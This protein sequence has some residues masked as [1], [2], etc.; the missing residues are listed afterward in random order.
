MGLSSCE[1]RSSQARLFISRNERRMANHRCFAGHG[2]FA[3]TSDWLHII[4]RHRAMFLTPKRNLEFFEALS[5]P[6]KPFDFARL[7][8]LAPDVDYHEKQLWAGVMR[9]EGL[10]NHGHVVSDIIEQL[11]STHPAA[12]L[13]WS[14][15]RYY[16]QIFIGDFGI[17]ANITHAG[18][19]FAY[20]ALWRWDL[21]RR[22]VAFG[23]AFFVGSDIH[24]QRDR[25][26]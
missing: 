21:R 17:R 12:A 15:G 22:S 7:H 8:L 4:F 18:W 10:D 13:Y 3:F 20:L 26:E 14:F 9:W 24:R 16:T 11:S 2:Y 1:C 23:K 25:S 6:D 5:P 19:C